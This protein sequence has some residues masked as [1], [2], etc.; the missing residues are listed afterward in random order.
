MGLSHE[1]VQL[2][3]DDLTP[4]QGKRP[5]CEGLSYTVASGEALMLQPERQH[6]ALSVIE[7]SHIS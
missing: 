6:F 4:A 2:I 3:V 1:C 7:I 5:I